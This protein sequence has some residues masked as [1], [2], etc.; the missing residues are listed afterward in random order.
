[1]NFKHHSPKSEFLVPFIDFYYFLEKDYSEETVQFFAF[2]HLFKPFN[3]HRNINYEITAEGTAVEG[4]NGFEPTILVQGVYKEPILV[5][6]QGHIDKLTIIFKDGAINNFMEQDFGT[7]AQDHTFSFTAWE[8][9]PHYQ[10]FLD[11]F[12][13]AENEDEKIGFLEAF[14]LSIL[15]IRSDWELYSQ[16]STLLK[17]TSNPVKISTVAQQLFIS[18][19]SLYRLILKYNGLSPANFRKIAQF[20]ASLATRLIADSFK[21]LTD[22]AYNSN[23]YDQ[24]YFNKIYKSLTKKSPKA[25]FKDVAAFCNKK[26]IFELKE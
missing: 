9:Y 10:S 4:L 5:K 2:P 1:M 8:Q 16:A 19:R 3:I 26:I 20:R 15:N 6:F 25:F 7:L 21:S 18:E 11:N 24:S 17:D 14:L 22:L 23:Y 13:G 12:F